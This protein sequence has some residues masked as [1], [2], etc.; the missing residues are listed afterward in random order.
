VCGPS[1]T[2]STSLVTHLVTQNTGGRVAAVFADLPDAFLDPAVMERRDG[3]VVVLRGGGVCC[4][5]SA[6][7]DEVLLELAGREPP[8]E[9][10]VVE[11]GAGP[12]G[13]PSP[14][15]IL[16]YGYTPGYRPDGVVAVVDPATAIALAEDESQR[17]EV[18]EQLHAANVVV[19]DGTHTVSRPVASAAHRWVRSVAK[20][21]T[22]VWSG[23]RGIA[24]P[25]LLGVSPERA[26]ADD[27]MDVEWSVDFVPQDRSDGEWGRS[28]NSFD[29]SE[30]RSWRLH[31][32]TVGARDFR[33]WAAELPDWI[34]RAS[35]TVALREMPGTLY[36]FRRFGSHWD[37]EP[38]RPQDG[39]APSTSLVLIGLAPPR[40]SKS[41]SEQPQVVAVGP[42]V[43]RGE[44][45]DSR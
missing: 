7:P 13:T 30:Y 2:G 6:K 18:V 45:H 10:V 29:A 38:R 22:V 1:A 37:L 28:A 36:D 9:H 14:R 12:R 8:P 33:R 31:G 11:V 39:A 27:R 21:A 35:G 25:L 41:R 34:V 20:D 40:R 4:R 44:P 19:L 16:G 23:E 26:D 3:D 15:R 24:A 17:T 5:G 42:I 43:A 32:R